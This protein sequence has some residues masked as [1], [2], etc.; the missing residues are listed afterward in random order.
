MDPILSPLTSTWLNFKIFAIR[1]ILEWSG[2]EVI[3]STC[4]I[5]S[6]AKLT[7]VEQS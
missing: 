4:M 5:T 7:Q 6:E 2:A 3:A 1:A